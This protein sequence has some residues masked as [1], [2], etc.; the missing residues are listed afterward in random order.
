MEFTG[1]NSSDFHSD[2]L[3]VGEVPWDMMSLSSFTSH[4]AIDYPHCLFA[5]VTEPV[6]VPIEERASDGNPRPM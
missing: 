3:G 4:Y 6:T 5:L 2:A 1:G